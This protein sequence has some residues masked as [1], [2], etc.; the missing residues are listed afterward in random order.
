[1]LLLYWGGGGVWVACM[2]RTPRCCDDERVWVRILL[3]IFSFWPIDIKCSHVSQTRSRSMLGALFGAK[4]MTISNSYVM[5]T[6]SQ[7][8]HTASPWADLPPSFWTAV[9]CLLAR[10]GFSSGMMAIMVP[11]SL[12]FASSFRQR[13]AAPR[14]RGMKT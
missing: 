5:K 10:L 3:L 11:S 2:L 4:S 14:S 9:S 6:L 8:Q 13:N 7:H 12:C 1:M